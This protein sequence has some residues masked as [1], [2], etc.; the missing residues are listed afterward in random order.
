MVIAIAL[1]LSLGVWHFIR[2]ER[3][4]LV[5]EQP[6]YVPPKHIQLPEKN[7]AL[8]VMAKPGRVF[9]NHRLFQA[10]HKLGFQFADNLVFEYFVPGTN[11]IA[12][13]VINMRKP[14][15]F[16]VSPEHM[17]PTNGVIAIMQLPIADGDQQSEYF[18]L[19]LSVLDD[20][21]SEL[22]AELC[23][24]NRNLVN[25]NKL[26]ELQKEVESFEQSYL[27]LIQNDYQQTNFHTPR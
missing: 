19:L 21:R 22:D 5:A 23:D 16:M 4:V 14:H 12:F 3:F 13:S 7:I 24:L 11:Y 6:E 2:R 8:S 1:L 18:H 15:T 9:D 10:M 27:T 17:P 25:N 20:L 26:Y